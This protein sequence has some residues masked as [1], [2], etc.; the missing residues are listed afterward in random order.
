MSAFTWY[1]ATSAGPRTSGGIDRRGWGSE[2][3][4]VSIE[5]ATIVVVW[6]T[7]ISIVFAPTRDTL[8]VVVLLSRVKWLLRRRHL[9]RCR[10][11]SMS[12]SGFDS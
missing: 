10:V 3:T 12:R 2:I 11:W 5:F 8:F 1:E 7:S 9:G 4:I 6:V